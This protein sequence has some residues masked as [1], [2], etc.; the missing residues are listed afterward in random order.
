M[1][2]FLLLFVAG[3]FSFLDSSAPSS[4]SRSAKYSKS[5]T[6]PHHLVVACL[7]YFY[8]CLFVYLLFCG[9]RSSISLIP[10]LATPLAIVGL[11]DD[12]YNLPVFSRFC[13]H[14]LTGVAILGISSFSQSLISSFL[15]VVCI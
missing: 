10:L 3:C 1:F 14:L 12:R 4:S 9:D 15:L 13:V 7:S 5:H 11:L 8:F 2:F 6:H